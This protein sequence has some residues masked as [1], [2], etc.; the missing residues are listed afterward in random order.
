MSRWINYSAVVLVTG[1]LGLS[2]TKTQPLA[3][4]SGPMFFLSGAL[5]GFLAI[6]I[7]RLFAE[8]IQELLPPPKQLRGL[9]VFSVGMLIALTGW[10]ITAFIGSGYGLLVGLPGI[11]TCICGMAYHYY[12]MFTRNDAEID[13]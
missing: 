6:G 4:A 5:I 1:L 12:L 13:S 2:L 3:Q 11:L 7:H 10:L 9:K 8:R